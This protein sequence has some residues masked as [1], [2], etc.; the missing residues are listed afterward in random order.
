MKD[1]K[2]GAVKEG[3]DSEPESQVTVVVEGAPGLITRA[4]AGAKSLKEAV[5]QARASSVDRMMGTAS[6]WGAVNRRVIGSIILHVY[7][8]VHWTAMALFLLFGLALSAIVLTKDAV[9]EDHENVMGMRVAYGL[10]TVSCWS[11]L[12]GLCL[13]L[14]MA[15]FAGV[16]GVLLVVCAGVKW[17]DI[18]DFSG[19]AN[20]TLVKQGDFVVLF[21]FFCIGFAGVLL[22][23]FTSI[24]HTI[25]Y[26]AQEALGKG[27]EHVKGMYAVYGLLAL[28][29]SLG[30]VLLAYV[31]VF[32]IVEACAEATWRL[33]GVVERARTF[34][35]YLGPPLFQSTAGVFLAAL[36]VWVTQWVGTGVYLVFNNIAKEEMEAL[37]QGGEHVKAG[38]AVWALFTLGLAP[39]A[40]ALALVCGDPV[41]HLL[42]AALKAYTAEKRCS[43]VI[44]DVAKTASDFFLSLWGLGLLLLL[45]TACLFLATLVVWLGTGIYVAFSYCANEAVGQGGEH[46]QGIYAVYALLALG[47]VMGVFA[48]VYLV[49]YAVADEIAPPVSKPTGEKSQPEPQGIAAKARGLFGAL[50]STLLTSTAGVF[51]AALAVWAGTGIYLLV[52][53]RAH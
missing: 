15:L 22:V 28:G 52:S 51:L 4:V 39:A 34:F 25:V 33:G 2:S 18:K 23:I 37:G 43:K 31:V 12:A 6:T 27:D 26:C 48:V 10:M 45:V 8:A 38:H 53:G 46:V 29:W 17:P 14:V 44:T 49:A 13:L 20:D 32:A 40:L 35:L 42:A 9:D 47:I 30:G 50:A 24:Y 1:G 7:F 19:S 16:A 21:F 3:G 5:V 41:A 11:G 36:M